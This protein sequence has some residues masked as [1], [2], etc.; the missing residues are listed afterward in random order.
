[1]K[2][3]NITYNKRNGRLNLGDDIQLLA[4][5]NLYKM[6]GIDYSDV[7][8]IEFSDLYMWEGEELVVPISFPI[9]SYGTEMNITCFSPNIVPVFLALSIVAETLGG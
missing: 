4:I 5:E 8:R 9:I 7:V 1:M 3:G 6:M 2:Y